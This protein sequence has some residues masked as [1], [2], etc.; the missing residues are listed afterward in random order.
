[1][2]ISKMQLRQLNTFQLA[3][4][5]GHSHLMFSVIF[6]HEYTLCAQVASTRIFMEKLVHINGNVI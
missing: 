2:K 3:N 5:G 1:M 6:L 4:Y